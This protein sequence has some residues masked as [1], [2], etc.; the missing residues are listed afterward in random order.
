MSSLLCPPSRASRRH[1]GQRHRRQPPPPR[2]E[3]GGHDNGLRAAWARRYSAYRLDEETDIDTNETDQGWKYLSYGDYP[4]LGGTGVGCLSSHRISSAQSEKIAGALQLS[5]NP[6]T[7]FNSQSLGASPPPVNALD[8]YY[9]TCCTSE[10]SPS[11]STNSSGTPSADKEP[12]MNDVPRA[13]V[14]DA[15]GTAVGDAVGAAVMEAVW[16]TVG[17]AVGAILRNGTVGA[18]VGP[19]VQDVVIETRH[20]SACKMY[21]CRETVVQ[22]KIYGSRRLHKRTTS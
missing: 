13:L 21:F 1:H 2:R 10:T 19:A 12:L 11:V 17:D 7:N 18:T 20:L 15:V 16:A 14:A 22:S 9:L 6:P 3:V 4:L 5:Y 8:M